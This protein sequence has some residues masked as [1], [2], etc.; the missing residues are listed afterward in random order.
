VQYVVDVVVHPFIRSDRVF[1]SQAE[2][3]ALAKRVRDVERARK[4]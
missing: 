4:K 3:A 2:A 1:S